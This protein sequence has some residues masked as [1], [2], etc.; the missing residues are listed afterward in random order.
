[1]VCQIYNTICMDLD[2]NYLFI[3]EFIYP[4]Q[5]KIKDVWC[6]SNKNMKGHLRLFQ[7]GRSSLANDKSIGMW[8]CLSDPFGNWVMVSI[9]STKTKLGTRKKGT[10]KLRLSN[11]RAQHHVIMLSLCLFYMNQWTT[12]RDGLDSKYLA[13]INK[14]LSCIV[15]EAS[16]FYLME[17]QI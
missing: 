2:Y 14:L 9:C 16:H 1:M 17:S 10:R 8:P 3:K 7:N 13:A 4:K 6:F 11:K 5:K 15:L 12:E